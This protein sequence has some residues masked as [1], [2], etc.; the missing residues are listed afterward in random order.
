MVKGFMVRIGIQSLL[1]SASNHEQQCI[2]SLDGV[3]QRGLTCKSDYSVY[4]EENNSRR[5]PSYLSL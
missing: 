3:G 4:K 1:F 2:A 5:I